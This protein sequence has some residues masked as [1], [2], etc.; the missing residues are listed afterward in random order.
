M[1]T[2]SPYPHGHIARVPDPHGDTLSAVLV[3]RPMGYLAVRIYFHRVPVAGLEVKLF[4]SNDG[5]KGEQIG[6]TMRTG[7]DGLVRVDM[8]VPATQYVCE[9]E[10]QPPAIVTTVHTL[11]ESFPLVL[12]IGRPFVDLDED[13][14]F[15]PEFA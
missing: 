10:R 6:E 7:E 8:L 4:E 1:A 15:D 9:I 11:E 14:E 13:H 12:P 2:R 5:E 3:P